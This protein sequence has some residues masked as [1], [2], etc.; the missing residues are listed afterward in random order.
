MSSGRAMKK[1]V[2][3][4][5]LAILVVSFTFTAANAQE[6]VLDTQDIYRGLAVIFAPGGTAGYANPELIQAR[7]LAFAILTI[8]LV[9]ALSNVPLFKS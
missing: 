4:S 1:A 5:I 3:L 6:S 2:L 8:I 9:P 7:L